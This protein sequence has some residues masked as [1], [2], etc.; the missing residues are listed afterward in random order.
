MGC[1][2]KGWLVICQD[3]FHGK[4]FEGNMRAHSHSC[5]NSLKQIQLIVACTLF[6]FTLGFW[7]ECHQLSWWTLEHVNHIDEP[8]TFFLFLAGCKRQLGQLPSCY[9]RMMFTLKRGRCHPQWA[10][11]RLQKRAGENALQLCSGYWG[12]FWLYQGALLQY[13]KDHHTRL[14]ASEDRMTGCGLAIEETFPIWHLSLAHVPTERC[15][16]YLF[17]SSILPDHAFGETLPLLFCHVDPYKLSSNFVM[18]TIRLGQSLISLPPGILDSPQKFRIK[19]F[20]R[21]LWVWVSQIFRCPTW[22]TLE[23][24]DCQRVSAQ[25]VLKIR[26]IYSIS[27][28]APKSH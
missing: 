22:N 16:L 20:I 7:P 11:E 2:Q 28:W 25:N 15:D 1:L 17:L 13:R 5:C 4:P 24:P 21:V 3:F 19:F 8:W 12:S 9:W 14:L 18:F 23:R 26:L 27:S 10:V 6:L